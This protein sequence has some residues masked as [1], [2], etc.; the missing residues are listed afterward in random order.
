MKVKLGYGTLL[1]AFV[2][3]TWS[4]QGCQSAGQTPEDIAN[5]FVT[6][7]YVD[8][9]LDQALNYCEGLACQKL[10]AGLALRDGQEITADT[11][12]PKISAKR[13]Q[14]LDEADGAKRFVYTLLVKPDEIAPFEREAYVKLRQDT[15]GQWKVSQFAELQMTPPQGP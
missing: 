11:F 1:V 3:S 15:A 5:A 14:I 6:A 9:N 10:R 4:L 2:L 8:A 13:T 7:Y 12:Q